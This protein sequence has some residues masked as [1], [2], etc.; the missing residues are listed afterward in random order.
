MANLIYEYLNNINNK[1]EDR[2]LLSIAIIK[3]GDESQFKV[4]LR[5]EDRPIFNYNK[6]TV[7]D[8]LLKYLTV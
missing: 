3:Y 7:I 4:I 8:I 6:Q 5:N 2:L 1:N